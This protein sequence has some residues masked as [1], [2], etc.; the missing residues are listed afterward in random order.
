MMAGAGVMLARTL[1]GAEKQVD[2]NCWALFSDIHIAADQTK[3]ARGINMSDNFKA[4]SR[5]VLELPMR[6]ARLLI[7]GD[8]AFNSGEEGD[9]GTCASCCGHCAKPDCRLMLPWETTMTGS[10]SGKR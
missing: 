4:A 10:I 1:P 8:C 6:P 2:E 3:T 7:N 5:E 9:Y